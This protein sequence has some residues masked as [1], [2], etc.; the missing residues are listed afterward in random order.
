MLWNNDDINVSQMENLSEMLN[1]I[2]Q[3]IKCQ[4]FFFI[5]FILLLTSVLKFRQEWLPPHSAP[6]A[7]DPSP[8][9][10]HPTRFPLLLLLLRRLSS[11]SSFLSFGHG[12]RSVFMCPF[13]S[14]SKF[15]LMALL[16][17]Y[18]WRWALWVYPLWDLEL[19]LGG[20]SSCG[21]TRNPWTPSFNAFSIWLWRMESIS[22]TLRIPMVLED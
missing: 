2:T 21:A 14:F 11:H 16:F 4:V 9:P 1:H 17:C 18:R 13:Y 3:S 5:S 15:N 6:F 7:S 8:R 20:T 22:S 19:G 10:P 12:R